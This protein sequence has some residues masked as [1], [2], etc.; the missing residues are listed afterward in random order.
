MDDETLVLVAELLSGEGDPDEAFKKLSEKVFLADR[1]QRR[2]AMLKES[3]EQILAKNREN[4]E[5]FD[6]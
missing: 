5:D 2:K 3:H 1:D 4:D 6:A